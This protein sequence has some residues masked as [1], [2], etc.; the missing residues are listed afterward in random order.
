[1]EKNQAISDQTKKKNRIDDRW[2]VNIGAIHKAKLMI[3]VSD[4]SRLK[5]LPKTVPD[6]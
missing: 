5:I 1:M 6:L 4:L 2:P 3:S